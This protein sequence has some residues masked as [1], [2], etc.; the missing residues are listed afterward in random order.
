M[1]TYRPRRR[2]SRPPRRR[3]GVSPTTKRLKS[4]NNMLMIALVGVGV[5]FVYPALTGSKLI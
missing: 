3:R 5:I 2:Y 4:N 1:A